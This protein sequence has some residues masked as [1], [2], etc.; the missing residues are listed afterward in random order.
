MKLQ[1]II[2]STRPGRIGPPIAKWVHGL[3]AELDGVDADL[4][5]LADFGLPIYDEP[6][7]PRFRNYQHD[8]TKAWAAS[9]A[10]ADAFVFVLPEYNG[11]PPA[12]LVN[13]LDYLFFEWNYK[14]AGVVTYGGPSG[15]LRAAQ[16]ARAH[17]ANMKITPVLESVTLPMAMAQLDPEAGFKATDGNVAAAKAMLAE[18]VRYAEALKVLR[19]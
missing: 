3:A 8:H 5:D 16:V 10:A 14:A 6:N 7:H 17:L 15:G 13:A 2:C 18:V 9:V 1:T 11:L 19:G 12:S 4:V